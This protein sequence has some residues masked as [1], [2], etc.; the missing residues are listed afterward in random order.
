M[1]SKGKRDIH[2]ADGE[3]NDQ[4]SARFEGQ[5][6]LVEVV[7]WPDVDDDIEAAI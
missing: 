5:V 3:R 7:C 1:A 4:L 6:E 2:K